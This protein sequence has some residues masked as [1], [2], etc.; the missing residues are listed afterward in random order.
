MMGRSPMNLVVPIPP[1]WKHRTVAEGVLYQAPIR[2]FG[3]LVMPLEAAREDP[4]TWVKQALVHREPA[5]QE[6][7]NLKLSRLTT[8][9]GWA[10]IL[11]EGEVGSEARLVAYF[12]FL[13]Y[14][15]TVIA[16]CRDPAG[17]PSWRDDAIAILVRARPDFS[18]DGV[19]C[20]A[21][22]LGSPPP[23]SGSPPTDARGAAAGWRRSFVG[24]DVVLTADEGP[25]TGRIRLTQRL[26][27]LRPM[28]EI[29]APMLGAAEPGALIE[30]P[31][32]TVNAEGEYSAVANA[33]GR[34][35]QH[36]LGVVFGDDHYA[37]IDGVVTVPEQFGR[38]RAAVR[39]LTHAYTLGLGSNRW[40][41]FYYEPPP[42]WTGVARTRAALWIAPICP[43][44]YQVMKVFDA[45]P[46]S[47]N[48]A[49]RHGARLFETL[50]QEFFDEPPTVPF[51][52]YTPSGL[53]CRVIVFTGRVPNRGGTIRAI[54]G[55]VMEAR[56]NYPVRMECDA[57]LF[58]DT[59]HVFER[60][61]GSI[62]PLPE[63][64][65]DLDPD[66]DV[67]TSWVD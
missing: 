27:P 31:V 49:A 67:L 12:G 63:R 51:V 25:Q 1:D 10:A 59:M 62:R 60:V 53:H 55:T 13:D 29:F 34:W 28:A 26:A 33:L 5:G 16:I 11:L 32:V 21:H 54:E 36:T 24:G 30:R 46:P 38:F 48:R 61:I 7:R 56:Y 8:E 64:G 22:Q 23:S 35:R 41:R 40:R 20:L 65:P 19:V 47:D 42:G 6:P 18:Q 44:Q 37:L 4:D 45:R 50:P 43:R 17:L 3:M 2:A 39:K 9:D 58:G 66:M 52:F 15:A 57:E 14:A